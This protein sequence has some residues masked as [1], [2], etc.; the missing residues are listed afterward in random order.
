MPSARYSPCCSTRARVFGF[1]LILLSGGFHARG[2][3]LRAGF[4]NPPPEAQPMM[5]WWWF[6]PAV[7]R[8]ELEKELET[9]HAAG[10]GGVEIQP[11]Y[12]LVLDDP[13]KGLRNFRYLSPEFL[14][15]VGFAN[16][17]GRSLGMRVS[18]TLGSGWPYGGPHTPLSLAAGK[19]KVMAVPAAGAATAAPPLE[20]GDT[21]IASFVVA[22]K[23]SSYDSATARFVDS[24]HAIPAAGNFTVLYFIASH[25]GQR[26][27]RAA[28]GAE[29]YV[30]DHFSRAAL[31]EHLNDVAT[32][33]VDAFGQQAPDSVFSDSL[34][35]YGSDWT[36][37]LPAEF[38]RRRG[39]DLISHLPELAAG[40]TPQAEAVRHDWGLTLSELIRE[41][42]LAP[43]AEFAQAHGTLFRSQTYG[44]PAVTLAD[45]A[46]PQLPEG[47]GPQWRA[48]SYARWASSAGHL[49]GR[50]AISAETWTWLHSP[51]FR[52]APLDMKAEA[53]RMFLIGINQLVGHGWPYSPP[54]AGEPGWAFY[55]A[56]VFNNHNPWFAVMPD[57]M[58]YLTRVSWL[59][60]QGKPANDVALL[61]PEDD[62]QAAFAPGHVSV[63]DEM[64][65]R[66]TPE[67]MS[68]ILDAGY[69][70]DYI[71]AATIEKL[72]AIPY[73]VL[74]IPPTTRIPL[75]AYRQ[76]ERFAANGGKV[77]AIG[78]TPSLA[79]GLKEQGESPQ[80]AALSDTLF[81]AEHHGGVLIASAAE[82]GTALRHALPPDLETSGTAEGLGF[83]HRRLAASDIYFI[84][85]TGNRPIHVS[86]HF[87]VKRHFVEAWD[88]DSGAVLL[89]QNYDADARLPVSLAPY[90]SQV[91]VLSDDA[92]SQR[93]DRSAPEAARLLADLGRG[94]QIRFRDS[95]VN[96]PLDGL[97]SWTEIPGR[98]FYS[99]EADYT[100]SLTLA[101]APV[102]G[103]RLWL[104]FGLGTPIADN[105]P[106]DANG[107]HA[108]L[109]PPIR[110]AAIVYVNGKRAGSLWH[111]PYRLE[112]GRFVHPGTNKLE[113][114][115]YNTAINE[116]AGRP[117][118]DY[119]TLY[120]KYGKRFEPQ[121]MENLKPVP[122]GLLGHVRLLAASE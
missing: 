52:A 57:V 22:G 6:G 88:P 5:R 8:P 74:V 38:R 10:I 58:R 14:G 93:K 51:A 24:A 23:P 112:I 7:V 101:A 105:R 32:P 44:E 64:R 89:A 67:L 62:A 2:Q 53:D 79:P 121:D 47:E 16:K 56:A 48:F 46:V 17:T 30:L 114:R 87:R 25:T 73:P 39:Y 28:L 78:R 20:N 12:P 43:L 13:A 71:D 100:R 29:G 120:A 35:V 49:Y 31:D 113:V 98:Q 41:N 102:A 85:N 55:A 59:L 75:A 4:V 72:G 68:A 26:V 84:A 108:L 66:I 109:D 103:E 15:D 63:T 107:M 95:A 91:F 19:L 42:Y 70:V 37:D 69:N 3:D 60:R 83:L 86:V 36:P 104:D 9:M 111:P 27:K 21:L 80:V 82:L 33:V 122:S 76:I 81:H 40:G 119:S 115:V 54:Q 99:G 61:L 94:W 11:V 106:P 118:R 1:I 18:I 45:E 90:E 65:K 77:I 110:E 96:Q 92:A 117:P 97:V 50:N 116:L 34:E